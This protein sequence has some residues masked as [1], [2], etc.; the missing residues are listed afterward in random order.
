MFDEEREGYREPVFKKKLPYAF[1]C[2]CYN[3][4]FIYLS[5][6]G[7]DL[8]VSKKMHMYDMQSYIIKMDWGGNIMGSIFCDEYINS[9]SMGRDAL[10]CT[11]SDSDGLPKLIKYELLVVQKLYHLKINM[12]KK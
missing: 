8:L 9:M 3:D 2:A 12:F 1:M 7:D 4:E 10:Y 5:Y 6:L 11:A